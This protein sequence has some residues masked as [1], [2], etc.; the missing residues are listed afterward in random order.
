MKTS[1]IAVIA[2]F[3]SVILLAQAPLDLAKQTRDCITAIQLKDTPPNRQKKAQCQTLANQLVQALLPPSPPVVLPPDPSATTA[4]GPQPTITCPVGAVAILPGQSIQAAVNAGAATST[5]CLKAGL[6]ALTGAITPKSGQ[7]FVGEFGA[8]LDGSGWQTADTT[9]GA[10]RAH[11]QDIDDVTIRNLVIRHMPQRGIHAFAD[12]ADRWTI[13]SNEITGTHTGLSVGKAS[14]VRANRIHH[15]AGGGYGAYRGHGTV[16]D[17]NEIAYNGSEQKIV[18]ATG[19]VF[20][21][22]WV[23]HNTHDGI[24][25]DADNTNA[26]IEGNTV[27]DHPRE[28]IFY[29]ISGNAIIRNNS[30]RR[31]GSSGLFLSTSRDTEISGNTLEDNRYGLWFFVACSR[32]GAGNVKADLTNNTAHDNTIRITN[33]THLTSVLTSTDCAGGLELPYTSGAKKNTF[34]NNRYFVP[35][36]TGRWWAWG[37]GQLKTWSDWRALG[38]D[39]TGSVQ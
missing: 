14:I 33:T 12:F 28:G 31:S 15:N 4:R 5:F 37:L 13:E 9:Q 22:N 16:F 29:E 7:T 6:H 25:Y 27:E 10:F 1:S 24:W 26:V 11:N 20:R 3:G 38:Q 2:V 17:N 34:Q 21:N 36:V 35:T 32:V 19:V 18:Q 39:A 8:I 23:H 30:I